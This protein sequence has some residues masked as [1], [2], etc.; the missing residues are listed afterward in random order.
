MIHDERKVQLALHYIDV[1]IRTEQVKTLNTVK[2]AER[3]D[4][5]CDFFEKIV[6]EG[7]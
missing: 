4:K 7:K 1:L 3:I 6:L 5:A 2:I